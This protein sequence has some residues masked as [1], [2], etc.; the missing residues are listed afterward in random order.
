MLLE[1]SAKAEGR[2]SKELLE[3][4]EIKKFIHEQ[5]TKKR[6]FNF[7]KTD[8]KDNF[9]EGDQIYLKFVSQSGGA[10]KIKG[11]FPNDYG[12]FGQPDPNEMGVIREQKKATINPD[13]LVEE[14]NNWCHDNMKT[15]A[16]YK[17]LFEQ[18]FDYIRANKTERLHKMN[19]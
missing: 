13:D 11:A 4:P 7:A 10:V 5:N 2:Y 8:Y 16:D 6:H 17:Y 14:L 18:G 19:F 1:A 12:G 15:I 9:D 3:K